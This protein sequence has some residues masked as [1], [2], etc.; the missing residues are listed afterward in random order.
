MTR[1]DIE[2]T[3]GGGLDIQET[4]FGD[5]VEWASVEDLIYMCNTLVVENELLRQSHDKMIQ[6][7]NDVVD[8]AKKDISS[9]NNIY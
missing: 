3:Q 7:L 2:P 5:W 1:F 9:I 4:P 8:V 6:Q